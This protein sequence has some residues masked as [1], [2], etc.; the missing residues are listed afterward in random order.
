[1]SIIE[2]VKSFLSMKKKKQRKE[3]ETLINIISD[4]TAKAEG[5]KKR[6]SG[7]KDKEKREKLEKEYKAVKKLLKKSHKRLQKIREAK[8]EDS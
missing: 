2:R 8:E 4:L 5:M 7:E 6:C 1:M 3:I